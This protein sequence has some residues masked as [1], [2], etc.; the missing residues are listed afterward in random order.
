MTELNATATD[1]QGETIA[2]RLERVRKTI[3][4]VLNADKCILRCRMVIEGSSIQTQLIVDAM[5]EPEPMIPVPA[6]DT[7]VLQ[8]VG[9]PVEDT[10]QGGIACD[11]SIPETIG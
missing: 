2:E 7:P 8:E 9:Y 3:A 5:P 4:A 10:Y 1:T 6:Q 11:S